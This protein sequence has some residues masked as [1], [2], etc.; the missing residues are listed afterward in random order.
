MAQVLPKRDQ[1][2]IEDAPMA[3]GKDRA[4]GHLGL[5]RRLGPHVA[6]AVGDAMDVGIDADPWFAIR[7]RDHEVRGLA[8]HAFEREQFIKV[9]RHAAAVALK[10]RVTEFLNAAGLGPI[11]A[12]GI[13]GTFNHAGGQLPHCLRGSSQLKEPLAGAVRGRILRAKAQHAA[14]ERRERILLVV[15][16][17]GL[18][19]PRDEPLE[20][21]NHLVNVAI[22]DHGKNDALV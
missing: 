20:D 12:N 4:Q 17:D 8:P 7:Q 18:V 10:E 2:V 1:Q 19:P 14:N 5:L 6:P 13:D 22:R 21:P 15:A 3:F 16:D 9:A 11:E